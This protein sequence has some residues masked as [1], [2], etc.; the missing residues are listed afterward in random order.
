MRKSVLILV[1]MFMCFSQITPV[2]AELE[3]EVTINADYINVRGGPGLEFPLVKKIYRGEVYPVVSESNQ[4][5]E[6][7]L[8]SG[9]TGWV[10][11]WLIARGAEPA[12]PKALSMISG[13]GVQI[14]SGP[15]KDQQPVG[16]LANGTAVEVIGQKDEWLEIKAEGLTGWISSVYV[17]Q[18]AAAQETGQIVDNNTTV[19]SDSSTSSPVLGKVH[20]RGVTIVS[21]TK[22]WVE[23]SYQ[24][25]S[26]WVESRHILSTS[27]P[28]AEVTASSL[29]VHKKAKLD[30]KK[31]GTVKKGQLFAVIAEENNM[32]KIQLS[33]KKTGWIPLWFVKRNQV[34]VKKEGV[35]KVK[36]SQI[37]IL[38]TGTA[39]RNAANVDA[40][41]VL[42]PKQGEQFPVLSVKNNWYQVKLPNGKKAYAAGWIVGITGEVK[43]IKQTGYEA[44][45]QNKLIVLD[46]GHGGKDQGS[47]GLHGTLEKD[48]TLRT[49][50]LVA[51]KLEASGAKVILTRNSDT[52]LDLNDRVRISHLHAADAFISFHYDSTIDQ[53]TSGITTY[54]YHDFQE[55]LAA[56]IQEALSQDTQAKNR[57]SRF[58]DYHVLRENRRMAVLLELGYMSNPTEERTINNNHYQETIANAIYTG[59]AK[60]FKEH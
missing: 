21:K 8:G 38:H 41:V 22:K 59:L 43:Q 35:E 34:S 2:K 36:H 52:H 45:L 17:A 14:R 39:L 54:Y 25:G 40:K 47:A 1:L 42:R 32:V 5:I 11:E 27:S 31:V 4:W 60:Y 49:V 51:E 57:G 19:Y 56:N 16:T 28:L 15:G 44:Y 58:G 50:R 13:N 29:I 18:P 30:S 9:T 26:G 3:A 10:A 24:S 20:K 48:V 12:D 55:P 53:V 33:S 7:M 37:V 46:P 23:I 6:I